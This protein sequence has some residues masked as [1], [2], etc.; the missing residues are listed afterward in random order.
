MIDALVILLMLGILLVGGY[1]LGVQHDYDDLA[2]NY[3]ELDDVGLAI[4]GF[5]LVIVSLIAIPAY[6]VV[7]QP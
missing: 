5:V 6:I 1:F 3:G 7:F 2:E 4:F